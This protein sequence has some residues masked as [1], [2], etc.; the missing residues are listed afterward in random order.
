MGFSGWEGQAIPANMIF[1]PEANWDQRVWRA[2][3]DDMFVQTPPNDARN[4]AIRENHWDLYIVSNGY[5][6]WLRLR[7]QAHQEME[8]DVESLLVYVDQGSTIL[9]PPA[10]RA[11]YIPRSEGR[12]IGMLLNGLLW[13]R[14]QY[15]QFYRGEGYRACV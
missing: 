8:S 4:G 11:I 15:F 10:L 14:L 12:T 1:D 5:S 13:W 2:S 7:F 9:I 6:T 3:I